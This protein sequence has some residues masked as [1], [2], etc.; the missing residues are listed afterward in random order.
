MVSVL[1]SS[2]IG[3]ND[4]QQQQQGFQGEGYAGEQGD[5]GGARSSP[6][7][8]DRNVLQIISAGL[9]V[10]KLLK[11]AGAMRDLD[12]VYA[13]TEEEILRRRR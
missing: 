9:Q 5:A 13:F 6:L 1:E 3:S 8:D 11:D 7:R 12:Q 2:L 4:V 10:A